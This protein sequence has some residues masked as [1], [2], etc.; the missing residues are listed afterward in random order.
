MLKDLEEVLAKELQL[1]EYPPRDWVLQEG[2]SQYDVVIVGAGMAGLAACFALFK[3]GIQKVIIYDESSQGFEGPWDTYARMRTLRSGKHLVGPALGIPSLTFQAY[4]RAQF[5][6][7]AWEALYKIP[8]HLWMDYLRWYRQVLKLPVQNG[9]KVESI[10]PEGKDLKVNIISASG[11][12]EITA[13]RV[14]LATGRSGFGGLDMPAF[15]DDISS[16]LFAHTSQPIDFAKIKGKEVGVVGIGASAFDAAGVALENGAKSVV[17]LVR[18]E[19]VPN[20]NKGL[21]LSFAGFWEGYYQLSDAARW[22][23]M[24]DV[25]IDGVPAPFESLDRVTMYPNFRC[26]KGVVIEK[27]TEDNS[28]IVFHTNQGEKRFDFA[29]MATGFAIDGAKQPE[30]AAFFPHIRLWGDLGLPHAFSYPP[31]FDRYPYL[32]SHFQFLEKVPF[33]AP[34][35]GQLYCFN[36]AATLSHGQVSGDIP[37]ISIGAERLAKGIAADFLGNGYTEYLKELETTPHPEFE[38]KAYPFFK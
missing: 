5:G 33:S 8:T 20:V 17:N 19:K 10:L 29:I 13:R 30:F 14:V 28:S 24:R 2:A 35:L 36:Y 7:E 22:K 6:D 21:Q 11:R 3:E 9:T 32:G 1:L 26:E 31:E 4:Y 15:M 34:Y 27:V 18:R 23:I 37:A 12:Q 38:E 25:Y 16:D